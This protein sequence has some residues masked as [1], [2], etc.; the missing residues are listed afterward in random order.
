[1][2]AKNELESYLYNA[3]NSFKED[4]VKE[5]LGEDAE[6]GLAACEEGI[7]WLDSHQDESLE[8]YKEQKKE[9]ES[10][11][12]PVLTKLYAGSGAPGP[13]EGGVPG[14]ETAASQG[15]KVEEVD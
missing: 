9:Y 4:K 2:E 14:F 15:P 6:T 13:A 12:S 1:V 7:A 3:R 11:I 10:K 5:K 8:I